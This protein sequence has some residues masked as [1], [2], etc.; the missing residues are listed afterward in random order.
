MDLLRMAQVE[1]NFIVSNT[2]KDWCEPFVKFIF[3]NQYFKTVKS[4]VSLNLSTKN[5]L[6]NVFPNWKK[7][8]Y[9]LDDKQNKRKIQ[10]KQIANYDDEFFFMTKS[11][12]T[13]LLSF[14][15][16]VRNAIAHGNVIFNG[17]YVELRDYGY[18]PQT[19]RFSK[20]VVAFLKIRGEHLRNFFSE[21]IN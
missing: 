21:L 6:H 9:K 7:Q 16:H 10:L 11:K 14:I 1:K 2:L 18:N 19:R 4:D 13:E 15:S 17:Q 20:T 8:Y 12:E 5:Y 3:K